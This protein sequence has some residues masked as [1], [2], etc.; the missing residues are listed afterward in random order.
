MAARVQE[1]VGERVADLARR[2]EDVRVEPLGEHWATATECP[3]EHARDARA[4]GHHPATERRRV[5][6][7]DEKVRVR[8][9]QAVVNEA[10][11]TALA[12]GGEAALERVDE[13]DGAQRGQARKQLDRHVCGQACGKAAAR[14]VWNVRLGTGLASGAG[15]TATPTG[16]ILQPEAELRGTS[17]HR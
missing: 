8:G 4:D 1:H 11:V 17:W 9:L 7:L 10:E 16:A 5:R 14:A 13:F 3:I 6:R 12:D 15:A 2:A